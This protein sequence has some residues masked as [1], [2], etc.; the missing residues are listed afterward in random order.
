MNDQNNIAK[1]KSVI[2]IKTLELE[3]IGL[4]EQ[5]KLDF[6]QNCAVL[7][8]LNGTG[9]TTILRSLALSLI[10]D[11]EGVHE[12]NTAESLLRIMGRKESQGNRALKGQIRTL[13]EI[14]GE[15]YTNEVILTPNWQTGD[16]Q[17]QKAE[18]VLF[19]EK[20]YL[21]SLIIGFSQQRGIF[22]KRQNAL[23]NRATQSG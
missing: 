8:G 20:G 4:F 22:T 11:Q 18:S 13:L 19:D 23:I 17:I 3:N 7:I 14:D 12:N 2:K 16:I 9:K 21:K 15:K 1:N 6:D 10:G 5:L